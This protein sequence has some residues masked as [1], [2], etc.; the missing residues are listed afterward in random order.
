MT[1]VYYLHR[2]RTSPTMIAT[3]TATLAPGSLKAY[4]QAKIEA[5]EILINQ[6]TQNLRH[7]EAQQ[8]TLNFYDFTDITAWLV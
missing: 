8:N 2:S 1:D 6:E 7:L 5:S 3:K 4:Y